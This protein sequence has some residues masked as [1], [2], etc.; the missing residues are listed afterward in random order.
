MRRRCW[1]ST[2]RRCAGHCIRC[3]DRVN[4]NPVRWSL[5]LEHQLR[6]EYLSGSRA[7]AQSCAFRMMSPGQD[8]ERKKAMGARASTNA[9]SRAVVGSIG[10]VLICTHAVFNVVVNNEVEFLIA[11]PEMGGQQTVDVVDQWF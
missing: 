2:W 6:P 4:R 1:A 11:K 5:R 3:D 8:C 10:I 9:A 7:L